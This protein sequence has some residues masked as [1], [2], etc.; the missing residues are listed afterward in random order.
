MERVTVKGLIGRINSYNLKT[1]VV[2]YAALIIEAGFVISAIQVLLGGLGCT[3]MSNHMPWALWI[4][5]DLGLI[6][7]GGGAFFT[8]FMFYI[9]HI[10][11]LKPLVNSAVLIG[12]L[13]Y[14]FTPV[15]IIFDVG[16]PV[17][18]WFLY[19]YPNWGRGLM[20]VSMMTEVA[21]CVLMYLCILCVEFTPVVLKNRMLAKYRFLREAGH[22][23]HKMMWIM[24]ATG[25]FLSFFHQGSLGGLFGV[26]YARPAWYG[27]HLFFL[28]II[29]AMAAGSS[30]TVFVTRF[31]EIKVGRESIPRAAYGKLAG[32]S[33]NVFLIFLILRIVDICILAFYYV[34]LADRSFPELWSG[35]NGMYL[36]VVE[37]VLLAVSVV[38]L[39]GFKK[40]DVCMLAGAASG[41]TAMIINK[42][43]LTIR[44]CAVPCFPWRRFNTYIP[45][46]QEVFVTAGIFVSMV[47]LYI[48]AVKYLP[49]FPERDLNGPH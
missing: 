40:R 23:L 25:T 5:G 6:A 38:L 30:F 3:G 24:A 9:L 12:L 39:N 14:V 18:S 32:I 17:R 20:P 33:G 19:I 43:V 4:V 8:G 44:G 27:P 41:V 49:V 15:F 11:E 42:L 35:I 45:S 36:L 26:L 31:Y 34:P 7:L 29:G 46:A 48:L 22:Y 2:I 10:D 16:Q 28:S 13:C 47:F 1:R 21:F 37:L